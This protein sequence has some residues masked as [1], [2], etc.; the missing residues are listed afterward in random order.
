[1]SPVKLFENFV[2]ATAQEYFNNIYVKKEI[3]SKHHP[4]NGFT[5][6]TLK[7]GTSLPHKKGPVKKFRKQEA[8]L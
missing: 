2:K 4:L 1:M 5:V 8:R 3:A 7:S 6:C